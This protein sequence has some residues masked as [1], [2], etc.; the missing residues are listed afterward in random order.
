MKDNNRITT[1]PGFRGSHYGGAFAPGFRSSLVS[2]PNSLGLRRSFNWS[3]AYTPS[4]PRYQMP[5]PPPKPE[6]KPT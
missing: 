5:C 4:Y 1:V 3:G 2:G 6:W